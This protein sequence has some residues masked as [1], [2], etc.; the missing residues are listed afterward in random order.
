M[1]C[2]R[3]ECHNELV[4]K[5]GGTFSLFIKSLRFSHSVQCVT[6]TFKLKDMIH[7][8]VKLETYMQA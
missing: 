8:I 7:T 2:P 5:N 3:R 1:R 4:R 6:K